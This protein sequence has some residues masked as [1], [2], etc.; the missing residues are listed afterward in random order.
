VLALLDERD[1]GATICPSEVARRIAPDPWRPIMEPLRQAARR[2]AH[3][4]TI[5]IM[6]QGRIVDPADFRGPICLRRR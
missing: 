2:L 3:A 5:N 4:G 6:H 1:R